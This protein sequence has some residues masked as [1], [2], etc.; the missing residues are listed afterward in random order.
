M[1]SAP[2]SKRLPELPPELISRVLSHCKYATPHAPFH[3]P[4][5]APF[6]AAAHLRTLHT[7]A[8]VCRLWRREADAKR[9]AMR[10]LAHRG[11]FGVRG[12]RR[13]Q[14]HHPTTLLTLQ[15]KFRH[16]DGPEL[17]ILVFEEYRLRLINGGGFL[18]G[19]EC[20]GSRRGDALTLVTLRRPRL[21]TARGCVLARVQ[22][23]ST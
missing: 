7:A 13:F 8:C 20:I 18:N 9:D 3:S 23:I 12:R 6:R 10:L 19:G 2:C 4:E 16:P 22:I 5:V 15:T 11:L 17:V 21:E 1:A 14:I